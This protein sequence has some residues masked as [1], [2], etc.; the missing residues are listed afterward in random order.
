MH[1]LLLPVN[2][3]FQSFFRK[4]FWHPAH[5]CPSGFLRAAVPQRVVGYAQNRPACQTLFSLF[6]NFFLTFL[7][8]VP[9]YWLFCS[10]IFEKA[11]FCLFEPLLFLLE[12]PIKDRRCLSFV[13]VVAHRHYRLS[14]PAPVP[15]SA[16]CSSASRA[17]IP[18]VRS[19]AWNTAICC[20]NGVPLL[21]TELPA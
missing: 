8:E 10:F 7:S 9:F 19:P 13:P 4:A 14:F 5:P 1:H 16:Y 18:P 6:I 12:I 17:V 3:F 20:S 2:N 15:R 11:H 21:P